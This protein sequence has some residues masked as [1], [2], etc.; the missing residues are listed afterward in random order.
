MELANK[1]INYIN[2]LD[3]KVEI[4][5]T[6]LD[7]SRLSCGHFDEIANKDLAKNIHQAY[8]KINNG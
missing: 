3:R 5:N 2:T 8:R 7:Y 4:I 6:P 1:Y